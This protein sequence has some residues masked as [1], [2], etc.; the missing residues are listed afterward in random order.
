MTNYKSAVSII[1]ECATQDALQSAAIAIKT[2]YNHHLLTEREFMALD[3][4]C[5]DKLDQ[6]KEK[7]GAL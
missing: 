3:L 1:S 7:Q 5:C 4:K 2:G 6:I